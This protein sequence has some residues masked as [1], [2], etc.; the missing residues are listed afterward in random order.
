MTKELSE[1]NTPPVVEEQKS[2]FASFREFTKGVFG[3]YSEDKKD[4][5]DEQEPGED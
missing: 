5:N 3:G 1:S 4:E 2:L